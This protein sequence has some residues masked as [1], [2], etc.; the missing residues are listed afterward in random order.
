MLNITNTRKRNTEQNYNYCYPDRRT[1]LTQYKITLRTKWKLDQNW[2][3]VCMMDA[4]LVRYGFTC[5]WSTMSGSR[6]FNCLSVGLR[7]HWSRMWS[8]RSWSSWC[9]LRSHLGSVRG[10]HTLTSPSGCT[11]VTGNLVEPP[12]ECHCTRSSS[13]MTTM[14][15][16]RA[17]TETTLYPSSA[18]LSEV[19]GVW[20]DIMLANEDIT[21]DWWCSMKREYQVCFLHVANIVFMLMTSN[22]QQM[23]SQQQCPIYSKLHLWYAI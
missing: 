21:L 5:E 16:T 1:N 22:A 7:I 23:T 12:G 8:I 17:N 19:L 18:I 10:C 13:M 11:H 2:S 15:N 14:V 6:K 4:F 3:E 20:T 9:L